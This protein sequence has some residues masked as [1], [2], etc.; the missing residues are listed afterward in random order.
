MTEVSTSD[1]AV[2]VYR[3]DETWDAEVLPPP[4]RDTLNR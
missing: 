3:E 4:L 1:F 2:V